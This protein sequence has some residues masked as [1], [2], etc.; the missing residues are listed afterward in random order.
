M[1]KLLII[2][3]MFAGCATTPKENNNTRPTVLD[4]MQVSYFIGCIST[5]HAYL[6]SQNN[7]AM[8]RLAAEKCAKE[9]VKFNPERTNM[10]QKK[11]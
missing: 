10:K 2:L 5:V 6:K 4:L 9:A 11:K 8:I 3:L 7:D 1:K